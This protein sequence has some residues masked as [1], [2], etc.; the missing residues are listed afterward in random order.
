M[1][2][3]YAVRGRSSNYYV[4]EV[5]KGYKTKESLVREHLFNSLYFLE[6]LAKYNNTPDFTQDKPVYLAQA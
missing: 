6:L 4:T 1:V 3:P 2:D 5:L